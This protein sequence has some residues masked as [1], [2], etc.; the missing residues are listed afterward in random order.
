MPS[1]SFNVAEV[2]I[3]FPLRCRSVSCSSSISA[4]MSVLASCFPI[5]PDGGSSVDGEGSVDGGLSVVVDSE[6]FSLPHQ[7]YPN[8]ELN[9]SKKSVA[10]LSSLS[11]VFLTGTALHSV[12]KR[13]R[14]KSLK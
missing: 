10:K 11:T 12:T 8:R 9:S 1:F 14:V 2:V 5:L 6:S 13:A 7:S 4:S 3:S